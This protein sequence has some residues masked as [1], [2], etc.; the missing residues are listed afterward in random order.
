MEVAAGLTVVGKQKQLAGSEP[1]REG[2]I[3]GYIL[4]DGKL[5]LFDAKSANARSFD[6]WLGAAG[7]SKW[8]AMKDGVAR[9]DPTEIADPSY[10]AVKQVYESYYMQA[11]GYLELINNRDEYKSYRIDNMADVPQAL[12]DAS[13]D[14]AVPIATEGMFF[15]VYCKDD[16]RLYEEFVPYDAEPVESRL[17]KLADGYA[18][19]KS[20]QEHEPD[21]KQVMVQ[22]I[23]MYQ[24]VPLKED[25][26][27][28]WKCVRCPFV[29]ICRP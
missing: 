1:P 29:E 24:E 6:E 26:T 10:R 27:K 8:Q 20:V 4:M 25:G 3:D 7:Q 28:H 12:A 2:H 19:V 15:Y 16:S 13:V 17:A 9:F 22:T 14:G 18:A 23:Q 5:W 11:L 21:N